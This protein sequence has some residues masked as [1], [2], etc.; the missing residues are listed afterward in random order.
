MVEK[1]HVE[2][3]ESFATAFC[4][5]QGRVSVVSAQSGCLGGAQVL[6]MQVEYIGKVLKW[7]SASCKVLR[8][9]VLHSPVRLVYYKS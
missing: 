9:I 6:A 4:C 8:L 1:Y 3:K 2:S 5:L 7:L